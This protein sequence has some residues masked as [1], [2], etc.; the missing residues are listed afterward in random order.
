MK[1]EIEKIGNKAKEKLEQI[2]NSQELNELKTS[3]L[4]KKGELTEILRGMGKIAAEERPKVGN[5]VN[6]A[7]EEIENMIL[8]KEAEFKKNEL[9]NKLENE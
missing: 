8:E 2:K 3:I 9:R 7:R 1:E 4:G 6:K 5:M